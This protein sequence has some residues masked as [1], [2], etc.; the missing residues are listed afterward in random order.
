MVNAIIFGAPGSG[1][2][3]Y[4]SRLQ[5]K[6]GAQVIATGDIFREL[7][8]E[9][10]P[11]GREVKSYVEKGLL[12]PDDIVVKVLKQKLAKT[13]KEKGFILDG[14]PRTVEQAKNLE[15]LAKIDVIIQL[16]VPD[17]IIIERLSSRRICKNCG[18]VY[19]LRYLKPKV[20][21]KCDKCGGPLY[22]RPDDMPEVIKKRIEVYERQ[23]QPLL[24]YYKEKRVPFVEYET[25][26]LE[27]PP[28]VAVE[29]ILKGLK[30]LKLV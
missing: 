25:D 15:K 20:D 30:R 5:S 13:S 7:M 19:N 29:E 18:E 6:I 11:L 17:W 12:V 26:K 2:G 3:T 23:T 16:K 10:T 21:M 28:E 9:D 14:Y 4:A 1:K 24:Q 8:K 27:T 22:Q